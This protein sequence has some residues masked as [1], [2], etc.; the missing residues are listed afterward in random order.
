MQREGY[1]HSE[2]ESTPFWHLCSLLLSPAPKHVARD[3]R[4]ASPTD[5]TSSMGLIFGLFLMTTWEHAASP[6]HLF[7]NTR[8]SK[9]NQD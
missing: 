1:H 6:K 5:A 9:V 4:L 7:N 2:G 3:F 8:P